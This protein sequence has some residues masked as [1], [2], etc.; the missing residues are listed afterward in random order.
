MANLSELNINYEV[1]NIRLDEAILLNMHNARCDE[2]NHLVILHDYKDMNDV[3]KCKICNKYCNLDGARTITECKEKMNRL[4]DESKFDYWIG[5]ICNIKKECNLPLGHSESCGIAYGTVK[6][7]VNV[8]GI[9]E[10]YYLH[11]GRQVEENEAHR[12]EIIDTF[13]EEIKEDVFTVKIH[14]TIVNECNDVRDLLLTKN[15]DYGSAFAFPIGIFAKGLDA[16]AQIRVRIDDKLNR[17]KTGINQISE[18]TE[19]D[20]IGYFILLRVLRK[21]KDEDK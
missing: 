19:M 10:K 21:I 16:E 8:K 4:F 7:L 5:A 17:L 20:L 6:I 18:D 12:V 14:D 13:Q 3:P 1:L 11:R 2:C 9:G 15:R